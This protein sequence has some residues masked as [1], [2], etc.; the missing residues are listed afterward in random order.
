MASL[1]PGVAI[2]VGVGVGLAGWIDCQGPIAA[3]TPPPPAEWTY[4]PKSATLQAVPLVFCSGGV[5]VKKQTLTELDLRLGLLT[6]EQRAKID[7]ALAP[8]LARIIRRLLQE[9][10]DRETLGSP[11][12]EETFKGPY[13]SE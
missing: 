6:D 10:A 7:R 11:P 1:E 4:K 12:T 5:R 8:A 9:E 2:G 13:S 3:R